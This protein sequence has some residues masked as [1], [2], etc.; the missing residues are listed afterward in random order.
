LI[1]LRAAAA[2]GVGVSLMAY[3]LGG[4]AVPAQLTGPAA[5]VL[6]PPI[7]LWRAGPITELKPKKTPP[8][9]PRRRR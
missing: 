4:V 7:A 9:K 2:P 6:S 3:W 1:P 8:G 5:A